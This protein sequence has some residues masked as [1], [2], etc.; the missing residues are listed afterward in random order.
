MIQIQQA[1][2]CLRGTRISKAR[3]GLRAGRA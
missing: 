1:E 3:T 2:P